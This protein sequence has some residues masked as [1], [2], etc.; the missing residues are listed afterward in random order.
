MTNNNENLLEA[1]GVMTVW[2]TSSNTEP[3]RDYYNQLL[4]EF[5]PEKVAEIVGGLVSLCGILLVRSANEKGMTEQ[6]VLQGIAAKYA[7]R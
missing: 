1:I 6:E 5:G 3:T 7:T 4:N 2:S